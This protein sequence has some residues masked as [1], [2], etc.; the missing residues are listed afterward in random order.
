[1]DVVPLFKDLDLEP[2]SNPGVEPNMSDV[3]N[4]RLIHEEL[5]TA[6][7]RAIGLDGVLVGIAVWLGAG[8]HKIVLEDNN[9]VFVTPVG[10]NPV[11]KDNALETDRGDTWE[12][13]SPE[14]VEKMAEREKSV[15]LRWLNVMSI[16]VPSMIEC[17]WNGTG[18]LISEATS[19]K[20]ADGTIRGE[21][22][23]VDLAS[24]GSLESPQTLSEYV[25]LFDATE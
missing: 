12:L 6:E 23:R 21:L 25:G 20:K 13:L 11:C 4:P 5:V 24:L 3:S 14:N 17:D 22:F 7:G 19:D 10:V 8:V 15:E 18:A 2:F 1:M 9:T 16:G